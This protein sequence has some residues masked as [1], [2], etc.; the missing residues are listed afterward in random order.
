VK[1]G[2]PIIRGIGPG[3]HLSSE[4][5]GKLPVRLRMPV[6]AGCSGAAG[7]CAHDDGSVGGPW[8][9]H[10]VRDGIGGLRAFH[11]P[12]VGADRKPSFGNRPIHTRVMK[13]R[14][15]PAILVVVTGQIG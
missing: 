15:Q 4:I 6:P 7:S 13:P 9:E 8:W 3:Q 1:H 12:S 10:S 5:P 2:V 11:T 14:P